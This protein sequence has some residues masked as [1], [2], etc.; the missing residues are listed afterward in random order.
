M[1]AIA[2]KRGQAAAEFEA[3]QFRQQLVGALAGTFDEIV[4]AARTHFGPKV[5]PM[6]I[7]LNAGPYFN[8][9][10]DVMRS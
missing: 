4:E 5:F 10:L 2:W 7:P 3:Q 9:L 1:V 8:R 6:S